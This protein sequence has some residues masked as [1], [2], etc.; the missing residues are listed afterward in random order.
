MRGNQGCLTLRG[1]AVVYSTQVC[2]HNLFGVVCF[3]ESY[4]FSIHLFLLCFLI[5]SKGGRSP[6]PGES[7]REGLGYQSLIYWPVKSEREKFPPR[8]ERNKR[9]NYGIIESRRDQL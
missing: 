2:D 3:G 1:E 5:F 4:L 9:R 6:Q 7:L 8:R